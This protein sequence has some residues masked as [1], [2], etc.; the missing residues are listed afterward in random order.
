M[1]EI[2]GYLCATLVGISL[3]IMGSG[4]S[5]LTVPIMVYMMKIN[6]VEAT[7]YSLF[8]VGVSSAIGGIKYL[9]KNLVDVRTAMIF[10]L[11]SI[12]CVFLTRKYLVPAIPNPVFTF[13][14]FIVSKEMF[15]ILF[16]A[17]LMIV[18]AYNMIRVDSYKEPNKKEIRNINFFWLAG[19]GFVS[20]LLTGIVGIG[21]GFIIVPALVILAKVPVRMSMGTSLLII[22]FNSISGFAAEIIER[23][24]MIDYKFLLLF[25]LFSVA[26]I[27]VGFNAGL[28]TSPSQIQKLF[29]WF[30]L[31]LGIFMIVKEVFIS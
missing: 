8:I 13:D 1:I 19:I 10:A 14:S 27:F 2:L 5:L 24:E 15:V 16:F 6:P 3:G 18:A 25:S 20:G 28:K 26:G 11:P 21:G 12:V 4:G 7:G 23:H 22:A 29:G 17:L 9:Q 31:S 30:I